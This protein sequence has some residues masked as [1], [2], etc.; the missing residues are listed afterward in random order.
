M[1]SFQSGTNISWCIDLQ[2]FQLCENDSFETF[3]MIQLRFISFH[4]SRGRWPVRKINCIIEKY[5]A[6]KFS[7]M[8]AK[9]R[10]NFEGTALI[11][12]ANWNKPYNTVKILSGRRG[13]FK[14]IQC[15]F[16]KSYT[17]TS[18]A[19]DWSHKKRETFQFPSFFG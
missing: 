13:N 14:K 9:V 3:L 10:S 12:K 4:E 17:G 18:P 15:C 19:A 16:R 11:E 8:A 1:D 7:R 2:Y 6:R 5:P